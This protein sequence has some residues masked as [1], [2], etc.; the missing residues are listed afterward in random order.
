LSNINTA[1]LNKFLTDLNDGLL[2]VIKELIKIT[3]NGQDADIASDEGLKDLFYW[4]EAIN[5]NGFEAKADD[6]Q[7]LK[8]ILTLIKRG[9]AKEDALV[10]AKRSL[11][12]LK[13]A[14]TSWRRDT[15]QDPGYHAFT[16]DS[17][18]II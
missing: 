13:R 7:I 10:K 2:P 11:D 12:M 9:E 14:E 5:N 15:E 16:N 17:P 3:H 18:P 8:N 6:L 1:T 4:I